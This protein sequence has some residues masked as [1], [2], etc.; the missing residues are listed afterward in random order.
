MF[1]NKLF[2][3]FPDIL[4]V[5]E[6]VKEFKKI[7]K[8]GDIKGLFICVEK[9]MKSEKELCSFAKGLK[10]DW[11]AVKAAVIFDWSNGKT[12]GNVNRLKLI[13]RKMY[14]RAKFDLLRKRVLYSF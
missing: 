14:G 13:K 9:M 12:E 4:K 1:R 8:K 3:L 11:E 5:S 10:T 2:E 7:L 6:I